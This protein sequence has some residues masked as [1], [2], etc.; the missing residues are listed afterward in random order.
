MATTT[1]DLVRGWL[2]DAGLNASTSARRA[3]V[4]ASTLHRILTE[5][6]D[7]S[8]G[9]L[10]EI[11][12]SCGV[13]LVVTS[14]PI[15]EWR[16]AAAARWML[17][18]GYVAPDDEIVE[19]QSRLVRL[20]QSDNPVDVVNVAALAS[21]PL[22]RPGATWFTGTTNVGRIA[23]A[24]DATGGQWALSGAAGLYLPESGE[25]AP[26][27]TILWCGDVRGATQHLTDSEVRFTNRAEHTTLV[28][29]RGEPELFAGSFTKGLVRYAAPIQIVLDCLSL[30]GA[31]ASDAREEALS[32]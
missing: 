2:S 9:T 13:D 28:V 30:G 15:S 16:A 20:A 24:G 32:W 14:R 10:R 29:V 25:P 22:H 23:S 27:V 18:D 3:G 11:A 17:E 31:V 26:P 12:I 6:V 5:Q 19:W 1:S 21:A 7:P 8:V 4:S